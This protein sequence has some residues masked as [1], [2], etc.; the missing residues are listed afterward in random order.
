[1]RQARLH[2]LEALARAA[3]EEER[4]EAALTTALAAVRVDPLRESARRLVIIAHLAE[5]NAP[6]ALRHYKAYRER[7]W[8]DLGL[9]PSHQLQTLVAEGCGP[10][11]PPGGKS[12]RAART[13]R[14]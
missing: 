9:R 8:I 12:R 6:D 1:M 10:V 5:G 3:L 11:S 7:L 2:T 4:P 14:P 13:A